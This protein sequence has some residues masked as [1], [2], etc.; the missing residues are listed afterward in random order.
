M[1]DAGKFSDE[2]MDEIKSRFP[3]WFSKDKKITSAFVKM[4]AVI[5]ATAIAKYDR[6]RNQK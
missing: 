5:A 4:G 3:D 2:V 6:K 1:I